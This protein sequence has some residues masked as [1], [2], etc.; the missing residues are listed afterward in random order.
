MCVSIGGRICFSPKKYC[1]LFSLLRVFF[2]LPIP[3][4][5]AKPL[6]SLPQGP[7][8]AGG[9]H[10]LPEASFILC[11]YFSVGEGGVGG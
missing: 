8:V 5:V 4:T 9:K 10:M 3:K 2:P 11:V 6:C 1:T 7:W